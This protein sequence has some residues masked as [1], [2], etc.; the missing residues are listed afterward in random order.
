MDIC[1]GDDQWSLLGEV[2]VPTAREEYAS[3]GDVWKY[4]NST[5]QEDTKLVIELFARQRLNGDEQDELHREVREEP[6]T[7]D[8]KKWFQVEEDAKVVDTL[9]SDITEKLKFA[10]EETTSIDATD[11]AAAR[12]NDDDDI[13][14]RE[15]AA[16]PSITE[17]YDMFRPAQNAAFAYNLP[18]ASS[19]LLCAL[20]AFRE[21]I[22]KETGKKRRQM[23]VTEI[24]HPT[25]EQ[26][27]LPLVPNKR[28]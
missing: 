7:D 2:G 18:N 25:T 5:R 27:E 17:L 11:C 15:V 14:V 12:E 20:S 1:V 19:H 23:L 6:T 24:L 16:L 3:E 9:C 26:C 13:D 10:D 22:S 8:V 4:G 21:E 28:G